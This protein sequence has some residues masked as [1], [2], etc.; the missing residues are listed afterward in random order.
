MRRRGR[1]EPTCTSLV[2]SYLR[3]LDDFADQAM[4]RAA[5]RCTMNQVSAALFELRKYRVADVVIEPNGSGW[6]YARP[7]TEDQRYRVVAERI[8]EVE[9]R[10]LRHSKKE[11]KP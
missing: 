10:R 5:T 4:I 8:P 9:P 2:E 7:A 3:G 1:K 6:W 11:V